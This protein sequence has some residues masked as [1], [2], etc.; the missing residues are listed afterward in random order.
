LT[1]TRLWIGLVASWA[2][3]ALSLL[4]VQPRWTLAPSSLAGS[5][6]LGALAGAALFAGLARRLPASRPRLPLLAVLAV[7]AGAEEALWR[8]LVL[9][10]LAN[11]VGTPLA[12][13]CSTAL[14]ACAHRHGRAGHVLT[15]A[16]FGALYVLGGL[17]AAWSAHA[18]YDVAAAA[19]RP[20]V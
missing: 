17:A 13:V 10:G 19:A 2:A 7:T 11:R 3:A 8:R 15:G 12:V 1:A 14:F 5:A 6:G 20:R 18:A 16:C 4:V 9:G